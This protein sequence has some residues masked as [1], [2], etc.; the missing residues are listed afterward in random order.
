MRLSLIPIAAAAL[1]LVSC[2]AYEADPVKPAAAKVQTKT[3]VTATAKSPNVVFVVDKSGSMSDTANAGQSQSKWQDLVDI[4]TRDDLSGSGQGFVADLAARGSASDPVRVG[5]VT[6]PADGSDSCGAGVLQVSPSGSGA[7]QVASVLNAVGP[8][9]GTPTAASLLIAGQSFSGVT[10]D[11]RSNFVVLMTDGAPNCNTQWSQIA[12]NTPDKCQD[13][14]S[15]YC[16]SLGCCYSGSAPENGCAPQ[17]CLDAINTAG[18]AQTLSDNKIG[19]FV[20]GFG[21]DV[22]DPN[23]LAYQ[24]MDQLAAAGGHPQTGEPKFYSALSSQDLGNALNAILNVIA[25]TCQ[26]Q[27]DSTPPSPSA[28]E[29]VIT[30]SGGDATTL[31]SSQYSVSGNTVAITDSAVCQEIT[32]ATSDN[33]VSVTFNFIG[34]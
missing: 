21:R 13:D 31:S 20:I 34:Q 32:N 28:V 15:G 7:S 5:L 16:V 9:G 4:M 25:A 26:Y 12:Q 3:T 8:N 19:T 24:T 10:E 2:Q 1:A 27:L 22:S 29:V 6:F 30:P 33:P 18:A 11:N 14:N 23:S 17:G